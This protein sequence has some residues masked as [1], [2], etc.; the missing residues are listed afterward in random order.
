MPSFLLQW[1][2]KTGFARFVP[3]HSKI[4][5]IIHK[6]SLTAHSLRSFEPQ[7]SQRTFFHSFSLSPAKEQRDVNKREKE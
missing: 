6:V 4:F 3:L 1:E 5:V 2:I 7:S